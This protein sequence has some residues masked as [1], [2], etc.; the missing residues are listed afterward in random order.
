MTSSSEPVG[1]LG[2]SAP[3]VAVSIWMADLFATWYGAKWL[4]TMA[5]RR[6]VWALST[7]SPSETCNDASGLKLSAYW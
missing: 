7:T 2:E 3:L 6:A 5:L 4:S 1:P